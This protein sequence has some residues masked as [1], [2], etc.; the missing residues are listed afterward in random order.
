[1][2]ISVLIPSVHTHMLESTIDSLETNSSTKV[3]ILIQDNSKDNI[4]IP[5]AYTKLFAQSTG[6]IIWA[7]DDD[8]Y[9]PKGWDEPLIEAIE[10]DLSEG[11]KYFSRAPIMI[12]PLDGNPNTVYKDFGRAPD[13]FRKE[14]FD[15][16]ANERLPIGRFVNPAINPN[17]PCAVTREVWE[18][19]GG[20]SEDYFPGFGADPDFLYRLYQKSGRKDCMLSAPSC[21]FY[22]F[23]GTTSSG[24]P[25]GDSH[26]LF[27]QKNGITIKHFI[28][29]MLS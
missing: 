26:A 15:T 10:S 20:W 23:S 9:Y 3:E 14:E 24:I 17:C 16:F 13:V 11:K 1:M 18:D 8:Y 2:K 25:R 21:Y 19:L 7:A 22:H 4:G 12:E 28:N 6:D 5:R 29:M 27:E